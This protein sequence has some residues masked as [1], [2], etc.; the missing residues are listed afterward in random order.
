MI[1]LVVLLPLLDHAAEKYA[2]N[3][4]DFD[5]ESTCMDHCNISLVETLP[6]GLNYTNHTIQYESIYD[7]WM[8]LIEMAQE[9]IE[10]ASLYWTMKREDVYPD[11]SARKA[12]NPIYDSIIR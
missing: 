10:I 4:T 2:L 8:D 11:D 6:I 3:S 5:V 1:V 9:T 12:S 7:S